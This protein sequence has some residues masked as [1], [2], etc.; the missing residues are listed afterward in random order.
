MLCPKTKPYLVG[1]WNE[2]NSEFRYNLVNA[3]KQGWAFNY[4]DGP[5]GVKINPDADVAKW[6]TETGSKT[7]KNRANNNELLTDIA[8]F[9]FNG[10]YQTGTAPDFRPQVGSPALKGVNFSSNGVN[11]VMDSMMKVAYRGALGS[12]DSWAN[13]GSWANWD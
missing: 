1:D 4:D 3:D 7:T 11:K 6:A 2:D 10:L 5:S 12:T 13:T 8:G 9:M